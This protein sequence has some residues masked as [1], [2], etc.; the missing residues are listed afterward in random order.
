VDE[1]GYV[2][3]YTPLGE[4]YEHPTFEP[5]FH[6][7]EA[8]T[9]KGVITWTTN[10]L[11]GEAYHV[12]FVAAPGYHKEVKPM[13]LPDLKAKAN[14]V[15]KIETPDYQ[16]KSVFG[17][18]WITFKD[19]K[20]VVLDNMP[21]Y[22]RLCKFIANKDRNESTMKDLSLYARRLTDK[23]DLFAKHSHEW[24]DIPHEHMVWYVQAAF[25]A[26]IENEIAAMIHFRRKFRKEVSMHQQLKEAITARDTTISDRIYDAKDAVVTASAQT[27]RSVSNLGQVTSNMLG[28][29][30]V[31]K[32]V[33]K[34]LDPT[35]YSD[36][37]FDMPGGFESL[38][39]SGPGDPRDLIKALT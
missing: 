10:K 13:A 23:N 18:E 16:I 11:G 29:H 38:G 20:S 3:Q 6:Q 26:D 17:Y 7:H 28:G 12:K 19:N 39:N 35:L 1:N 14:P 4:K 5:Y 15:I 31:L 21:L 8:K 32:H 9:S 25:Y 33:T 27:L 2:H 37:K 36:Q 34:F 30:V 24:Y 22:D